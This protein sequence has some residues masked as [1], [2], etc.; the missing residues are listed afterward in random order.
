MALPEQI[1]DRLSREPVQTPGWS[2]RLLMFSGT[3]FFIS[4][5]LYVGIVYGYKPYLEKEVK[6]LDGQIKSFGQ[7]IP[8]EEQI[9]LISFYSQIS[10][11]QSV[12]GNHVASSKFLEWLEKNTE[13]NVYY[14]RLSLLSFSDQAGLSGVS[15][16]VEDFSK[17]LIVFQNNPLIQRVAINSFSVSQNNLWQFD[18]TLY[19]TKGA[20]NQSAAQQ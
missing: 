20:L 13:T 15:K 2:G 14:T 12:F 10:N 19:M 3:I 8:P 9:K 16:T 6:D 4:L 18:I 17:Q 1:V 11:I 5:A 7:K